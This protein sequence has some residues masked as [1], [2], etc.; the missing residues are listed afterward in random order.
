ML[1]ELIQT[2]ATLIN[3]LIWLQTEVF[4]PLRQVCLRNQRDDIWAHRSRV[5]HLFSTG[6][7]L[8]CAR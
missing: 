3:A 8:S 1:R 5:D 2:E 4:T 6:S 7:Q